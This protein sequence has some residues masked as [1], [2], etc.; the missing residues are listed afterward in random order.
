MLRKALEPIFVTEAGTDIEST[1]PK[2]FTNTM[3]WIVVTPLGIVKVSS[4]V[5]GL[6]ISDLI[7]RSRELYTSF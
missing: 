1:L 5:S 6:Q 3:L 4:S 2:P 7:E